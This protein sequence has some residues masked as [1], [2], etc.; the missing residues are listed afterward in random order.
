[1]GYTTFS[2]TPILSP[3]L[4][5]PVKLWWC[6]RHALTRCKMILPGN[7]QISAATMSDT[8]RQWRDWRKRIQKYQ[9]ILTQRWLADFSIHAHLNSL[10][11]VWIS[12]S[13]WFKVKIGVNTMFAVRTCALEVL[14]ALVCCNGAD[15][16]CQGARSWGGR[17]RRGGGFRGRRECYLQHRSTPAALNTSDTSYILH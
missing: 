11:A 3:D 9:Q 16:S 15:W 5:V 6:L 12:F 14:F 17:R 10:L 1:M 7:W 13:L 8:C 2:D 4:S